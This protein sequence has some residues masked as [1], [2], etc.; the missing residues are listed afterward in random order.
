M[1]HRRP[2]FLAMAATALIA[3]ASPVIAQDQSVVDD[4]QLLLSQIQADRSAIV[5]KS[6][7]LDDTQMRAF[8]P[9]FD[10]YQADR[11]KLAD[12][13]VELVNSYAAN[14]D[15]MTDDAAKDILKSWFKLQ[16][17]ETRLVKDYAKKMGKV[18][19][20][21]KVLRF[22]QIEN[23]LTTILRLPTV[24]GIPLAQ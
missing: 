13:A 20:P 19:P 3:L 12:R 2:V 21:A 10:A 11:K 7:K 1:K 6:M 15:S 14:Y 9:V 8:T 23:K 24:R 4:Q 5:L 17:D 22:V 18:L 16:D